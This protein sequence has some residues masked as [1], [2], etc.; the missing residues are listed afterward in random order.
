MKKTNIL[1]AGL[2]M[3]AGGLQ[4]A[5]SANVTVNNGNNIEVNAKQSR[6]RKVIKQEK[7]IDFDGIGGINHIQWNAGTPPKQYGQ[8]LQSNRRQKWNK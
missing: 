3:M 2:A 1:L 6:E 4:A 7:E 5:P 8:W